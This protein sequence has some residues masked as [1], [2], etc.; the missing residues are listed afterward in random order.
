[1]QRRVPQF[2][3]LRLRN[4]GFY[5][6]VF[7]IVGLAERFPLGGPSQKLVPVP[8]K[9]LGTK[10]FDAPDFVI[11]HLNGRIGQAHEALPQKINA[12]A[13]VRRR[14]HHRHVLIRNHS[15]FPGGLI[16][17]PVALTYAVL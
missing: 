16:N 4:V 11:L 8:A 15:P 13:D 7:G 12:M 6:I 14:R 9:M 1:M 2:L 5:S 17:S 3:S 10:T